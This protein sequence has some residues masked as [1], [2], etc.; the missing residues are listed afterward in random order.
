LSHQNRGLF[1]TDFDGTLLR[2]D[3]T[4]AQRDLDALIS[5]SR[6]GITTAVATGRSLY[7]FNTSPGVELPVDYIIFTTGAGV[8]NRPEG[9][10]VYRVNLTRDM[11]M[12]ALDIFKEYRLDF[13]LHGPV[14]DNYKFLYCRTTPNNPDFE[15]RLHRYR[16]FGKPFDAASGNGFKE[17][18]QLLAVIPENAVN[19]VVEKV[20]E[21]LPELSVIKTTSPLDHQSTWIELFHPNVSK[22]KTT[23]WL[24]AELAVDVLN[25]AAI[26][27]DY[28]DQDLLEWASHSFVVENAP[29]DLKNRFQP[30]ASNNDG[31]VAEAI[32]NWLVR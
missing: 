18:S 26:G 7:S 30:V 20:R 6:R 13:F 4:L 21:A 11:A 27:N 25:T 8:V 28:N 22:S 23:A 12:Q 16:P 2:S 1:I 24:A 3:G 19:D 17:V 32:E 15:T 10:L 9:K 31:G 5:L 29:E 14:P